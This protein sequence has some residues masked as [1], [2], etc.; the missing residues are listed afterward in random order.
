[1]HHRSEKRNIK[2]LKASVKRATKT[3]NLFCNI[4]AKRIEKRCCPFYHPC[5]NLLTT[6]LLQ[7]RFDVGGKTRNIAIQPRFAAMLQDKLHVFCCLF[8]R[9][10]SNRDDNGKKNNWFYEPN[11]ISARASRLL[12]LF[13][14]V[15]CTTTTWNF[16]MQRFMEDA[17]TR[18]PI[19]LTCFEPGYS[20]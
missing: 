9:A 10:L 17:N 15:H 4:A 11:N 6:D 13:F 2:E 16:R 8:F 5:S 12:V 1:M 19:L 14:N 3:C 20:P 7:D 18:R